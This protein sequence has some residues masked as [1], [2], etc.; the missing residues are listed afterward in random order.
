MSGQSFGGTAASGGTAAPASSGGG[1]APPRQ[2][3]VRARRGQ[4]TDPHSIAERVRAAH[5]TELSCSFGSTKTPT[6]LNSFSTLHAA[7]EGEDSGADEVP[8][9]ARP[10][11]QQGKQ[12]NFEFTPYAISPGGSGTR[13]QTCGV[14]EPLLLCC[15]EIEGRD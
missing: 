1:A 12:A 8:A 3:R 13:C 10:Q 2:T 7:P 11:R 5:L 6:N 9:R 4:A 14:L 15:G